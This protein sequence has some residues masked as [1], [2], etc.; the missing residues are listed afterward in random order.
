MLADL[1]S[2]TYA[3]EAIADLGAL[4]GDRGT[5]DIRLEAA[6]AKLWNSDAAWEVC[7][8]ALQIR[9]GRGYETARSLASRGE[10]PVPLE[11]L[12]RDLRINRIFEGTNQIMRLFIAREAL[13]AH[14][15]A[16][17]DVVMPGVPPAKRLTGL[18]RAAR[19][20]AA[21]YPARWL[22][23]SGW[24]RYAGF[25]PLARHLRWVDRTAH[26]LARQQFHLMV[27]HGPALEKKQAQLFRCVDI[28]AELFAMAATCVRAHD[29]VRKSAADSTPVKLADVFCRQ[30]RLKVERLFAAI[31]SNADVAAY[32][33]ARDVLAG[34]YAWL[35]QGIIDAPDAPRA[36]PDRGA[37]AAGN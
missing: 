7:D 32:G 11:Q 34:R 28:G 12:F 4:L 6:I 5:S 30:S 20:Y 37:A 27:Q 23:W 24:P 22:S 1:A 18:L 15:K 19:F 2:R 21:W 9:G 17:G 35:E 10:A 31:R 33:L 13:D 3:M 26:R 36:E 29:D 25:G 8:E 16:A 14:L